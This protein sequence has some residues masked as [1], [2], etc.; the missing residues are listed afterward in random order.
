MVAYRTLTFGN[1]RVEPE[2]SEWNRKCSSGADCPRCLGFHDD[3]PVHILNGFHMVLLKRVVEESFND[4]G[5]TYSCLAHEHYS[6][7]LLHRL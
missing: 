4:G 5:F 3:L 6:G 1:V 2:M 7:T